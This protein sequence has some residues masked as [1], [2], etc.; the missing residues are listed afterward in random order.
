MLASPAL[1]SLRVSWNHR[2]THSATTSARGSRRWFDEE[3][4]ELELELELELAS[5]MFF[6]S[7][8]RRSDD[9][10]S[11]TALDLAVTGDGTDLILDAGLTWVGRWILLELIILAKSWILFGEGSDFPIKRRREKTHWPSTF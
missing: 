8:S 3:A 11:T 7:F 6:F 1:A 9:S 4:L 5:S 2:L 10:P